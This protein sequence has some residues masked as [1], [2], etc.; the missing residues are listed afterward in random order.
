MFQY[1]DTI[2]FK[3]TIPNYDIPERK[4][5]II[6]LFCVSSILFSFW[7]TSRVSILPCTWT[8]SIQSSFLCFIAGLVVSRVCIWE[9]NLFSKLDL[10]ID[11]IFE[12]KSICL[13]VE[14]VC[15][16]WNNHYLDDLSFFAPCFQFLS[17]LR[18]TGRSLRLTKYLT[19]SIKISRCASSVR[20]HLD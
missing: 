19:Y 15:D 2:N 9:P 11:K 13:S 12:L 6:W 3:Q 16:T 1:F 14:L 4:A 7:I 8:R 10:F 18:S 5:I 17:S 20:S